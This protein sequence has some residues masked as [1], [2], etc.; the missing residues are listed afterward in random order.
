MWTA[1]TC[2][3][4]GDG[5]NLVALPLLA[6]VL[7][8][9]PIAVAMV[10]LLARLP[11]ALVAIPAGA[12]ADR[13]NRIRL[14]WLSDLARAAL[15][16][17]LAALVAVG[18][19]T[20]AWLYILAFAVGV[21]DT[22]FNASSQAVL[23]AVVDRDQLVRANGR[24][25]TSRT[26]GHQTV[27][28]AIG[29]V[30]F[31]LAQAVPFVADALSFL[32]SAGV[33]SRLDDPARSPRSE[34]ADAARSDPASGRP[35]AKGPDHLLGGLWD[36]MKTGLRWYRN[37]ASLCLVTGTV[38]VLAFSQAMINGI[39][40]LFAL[41]RLHLGGVGYGLFLGATALGNV[42]GG[43]TVSRI[44]HQLGTAR[45]VVAAALLAAAGYAGTA[46]TTSPVVAGLL[47]TA[48]AVVVVVG[49]VATTS[50][51]Q[52][53]VPPE[54]QARVASVW[55]AVV[56]GAI[57]LGTVVG[58]LVADQAG[59][60]GPFLVAAVVQVAL[61]IAVARPLRRLVGGDQSHG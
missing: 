9:R 7:T 42:A 56:W 31:A 12:W 1:S 5:L 39:L 61:A 51:R 2:S 13:T 30:L 45:V 6:T 27:G 50:F 10:L 55:R 15:V 46:V 29:G 23:P 18:S 37:S 35:G 25:S 19:I 43:L 54:L 59:L 16:G 48:E 11:W 34:R 28:P 21:F 57:P 47:M 41:E 26:A 32:G 58:G 14:M 36:D 60:R 52:A 17:L 33:L 38:A 53:L 40:V 24:L 20:L 49:N 8:R 4:V 22:L 44:V 3:A